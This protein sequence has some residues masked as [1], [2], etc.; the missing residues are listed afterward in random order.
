MENWITFLRPLG[1][2]MA[3][4]L[5]VFGGLEMFNLRPPWWL[6]VLVTAWITIVFTI[7]VGERKE[8]EEPRCRK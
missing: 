2:T 5:L 7:A 3:I 8:I 1:V 6:I 4:G